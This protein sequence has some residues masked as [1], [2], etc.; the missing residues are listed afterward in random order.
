MIPSGIEPA[1]FRFVA[2]NLNQMR[3]GVPPVQYDSYSNITNYNAAVTI[4][5]HSTASVRFCSL[6][7]N[8]CVRIQRVVRYLTG[9]KAGVNIIL[10]WH[11]SHNDTSLFQSN[12]H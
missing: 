7:Y 11:Y 9:G 4:Q 12:K 2:Q 10:Y 6:S 5:K 8:L 3:Q 1:T